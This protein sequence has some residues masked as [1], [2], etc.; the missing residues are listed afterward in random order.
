MLKQTILRFAALWGVCVA[1]NLFLLNPP[2][3]VMGL[4]AYS[5]A[6]TFFFYAFSWVK[7][8]LKW[9]LAFTGKYGLMAILFS[10]LPAILI[11]AVIFAAGL[12][13]LCAVGVALGSIRLAYNIWYSICLDRQGLLPGHDDTLKMP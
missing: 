4:L 7:E 11:V 1:A 3:G 6:G 13:V 5:L 8:P 10:S 9:L 12:P 2:G